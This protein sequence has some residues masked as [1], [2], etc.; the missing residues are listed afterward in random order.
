[1]PASTEGHR[2]HAAEDFPVSLGL[3]AVLVLAV[4]EAVVG[5]AGMWVLLAAH[6]ADVEPEAGVIAEGAAADKLLT[7]VSSPGGELPWTGWIGYAAGDP[8]LAWVGEADLPKLGLEGGVF[9]ETISA[10]LLGGFTLVILLNYLQNSPNKS[11]KSDAASG[12]A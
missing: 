3:V 7:A 8:L 4:P 10:L 11:L 6:V 2:D 12:A 5:P 1:M 9:A